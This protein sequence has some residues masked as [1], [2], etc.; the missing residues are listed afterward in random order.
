ME[1]LENI[2]RL[3]QN[4]RFNDAQKALTRAL[5]ETPDSPDYL[6]LLG[7]LKFHMSEIEEAENILSNV[8][9]R[10]PNHITG[11]NNF[12]CLKIVQKKWF[13]AIN[14]LQRVCNLDGTC[15]FAVE[16]LE[17]IKN[18]NAIFKD[19]PKRGLYKTICATFPRSGHDLLF[20]CLQ[21]YFMDDFHYCEFYHH[22]G[23]VP[24]ADHSTN[25][26]KNHDFD[27]T[28]FNNPAYNYVIQYR[29]PIESIISWYNLKLSNRQIREDTVTIWVY[30]LHQKIE[31]WKKFVKKW[32]IENK[33]PYVYYLNYRDF[34]NNP[35][36]KLKE[37]VEFLDPS[38]PA[39][40]ALISD[41]ISKMHICLRSDIKKFRYYNPVLFRQIESRLSYELNR[42]K[43]ACS[44]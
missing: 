20:Q 25:F 11:L 9:M 23:K 32:I 12:A 21:R 36:I 28:L 35:Q 4:E 3:L 43:L 6:S 14:L 18:E 41:I 31:F 1:T 39:N 7:E 42:L 19:P 34:V 16:N 33:N 38:T 13:E 37:T 44:Y 27:L 8:I 26:Q 22:C 17:F 29:H 15:Q 10:W 24:C 40:M 2:N 30:F 5:Q